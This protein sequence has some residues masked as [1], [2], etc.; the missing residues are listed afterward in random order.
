MIRRKREPD[1]FISSTWTQIHKFSRRGLPIFIYTKVKGDP[2]LYLLKSEHSPLH[3]ASC[4]V[5]DLWYITNLDKCLS[6]EKSSQIKQSKEQ[7]K[8]TD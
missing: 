7:I 6:G 5:Q 1:I 4:I 8:L 3:T 2:A